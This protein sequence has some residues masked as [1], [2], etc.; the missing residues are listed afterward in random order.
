MQAIIET[1][2]N[3]YQEKVDAWI[4]EMKDGMKKEMMACQEMTEACLDCKEPTSEEV[5]SGV[6]H[7]E[8]SV[9]HAAVK[10]GRELKKQH[11]GR[12]PAAGCHRKLNE[13][14]QGNDGYQKKL[15]ATDRKMTRTAQGTHC[16]QESY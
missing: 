5:E 1:K 16:Q 6:E 10:P 12:H 15:A 11:K 3:R 14:T 8:V 7:R 4:A 2:K 9:E 13:W